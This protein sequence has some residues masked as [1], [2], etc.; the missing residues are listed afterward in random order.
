MLLEVGGVTIQRD[1]EIAHK[2]VADFIEKNILESKKTTIS[3][4]FKRIIKIM[5]NDWPS[6]LYNV[7]D[8]K[9]LGSGLNE[10]KVDKIRITFFL[11]SSSN[12][13]YLLTAFKKKTQKTPKSEL[14]KAMNRMKNIKN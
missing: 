14:D 2:D 1:V 5:E 10:I 3:T 9:P 13:F 6:D 8:V 4:N 11:D 12:T 7:E